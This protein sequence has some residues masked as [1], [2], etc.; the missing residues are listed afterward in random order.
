MVLD[1]NGLEILSRDEC[2]ELLDRAHVGRIGLCMGAL[3]VILPI[4]LRMLD[5][6]VIV[7]SGP[8]SKLDAALNHAVVALEVDA[9][10]P[11]DHTGWSVMVQGLATEIVDDVGRRRADGS[12]RSLMNLG[13]Q[14]LLRRLPGVG[15]GL[16]M[17]PFGC[18]W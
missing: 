1:R 7:R 11:F 4:N 8:G 13:A 14:P 5:G 6:D 12:R 16:D 10:S 15:I 18:L 3:P 2:L 9:F 17:Q